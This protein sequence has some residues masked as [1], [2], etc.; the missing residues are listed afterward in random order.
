MRIK[1]WPMTARP[2]RAMSALE[3][4]GVERGGRERV[5]EKGDEEKGTKKGSQL[6]WRRSTETFLSGQQRAWHA[7]Y[8]RHG[9]YIVG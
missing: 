8:V 6:M 3:A 7:R 4:D 5:N 9:G 2:M 1:F